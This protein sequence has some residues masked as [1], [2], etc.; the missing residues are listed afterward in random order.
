[1]WLDDALWT[2]WTVRRLLER[3]II[4]LE[5]PSEFSGFPRFGTLHTG[6]FHGVLIT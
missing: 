3:E 5:L 6:R 4:E 2:V 1:M